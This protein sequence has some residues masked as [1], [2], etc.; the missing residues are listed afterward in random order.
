MR[1]YFFI[2]ALLIS[3]AAVALSQPAAGVSKWDQ[4]SRQMIVVKT[5]GWENVAGTLQR[6]EREK[7][8]TQWKPVGSPIVVVVGRSGLAW[9]RGLHP[10]NSVGPQK[11]EGDGKSPAGVF[12]LSSAFGFV[13]GEEMKWLKLPYLH[14]TDA[15]ECVDDVKSIRYNSIVDNTHVLN[16]DWSSSEKMREIGEQYRLGVVVNHNVAPR[17]AGEGSCIFLH[18][19]KG[20]GSGTA[21]CTAMERRNMEEVVRWLDSKARP[22]LVQ[23][24][25]SEFQ[26]LE[27]DWY[28][29]KHDAAHRSQ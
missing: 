8:E 24:P 5:P 3:V 19:W 28:L 26:R 27:K 17:I 21:G 20:D 11:I 14:V 22:I 12:V 29:P 6:F 23:L 10:T 13:S 4:T 18:I 9:G 2:A 15:M 16:P 7:V 1:K 25:D